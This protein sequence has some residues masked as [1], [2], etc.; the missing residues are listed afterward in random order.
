MNWELLVDL[1]VGTLALVGG[2]A[3]LVFIAMLLGTYMSD[4]KET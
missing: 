2:L 1:L 4:E 3:I